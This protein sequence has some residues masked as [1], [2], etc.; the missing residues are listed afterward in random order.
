MRDRDWRILKE[1]FHIATKGGSIPNP[2]R[3]WREASISQD[4]LD[5]L[6]KFSYYEPSAI[7]RQA[8][9]II[10]QG[11][12]M[13]GVAETGS[14]KT[15]AFLVPLFEILDRT[16]YDNPVAHQGPFALIL[17]PTREL[18]LQIEAECARFAKFLGKRPPVAVVGG[19]S[20]AEQSFR[21][22]R[23]VDIVVATPG[24]LKD[25]LEQHILSLEHVTYTVFDEADRMVDMGFEADLSFILSKLRPSASNRASLADHFASSNTKS[26]RGPQMIMFSATM[27]PAVERLVRTYLSNPATVTI[28]IIGQVVDTIEQKVELMQESQKR[29]RLFAL[30]ETVAITGP[31]IVFANLKDTIDSLVRHMTS[32]GFGVIGLHGG[33][34]QEQRE[35]ALSKLKSG[36]INILVAT[37]VASRGI[38]VPDVALV[39]NFDM[40]SSI[41][42]YIHRIGRTGRAGK[43]GLAYT[44]LTQENAP[45]FY[46]L[47]ALLLSS[48]RSTCPP[49]LAFHEAANVKPGSF[50]QKKKSDETI[51]K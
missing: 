30:L 37:D 35:S 3:Y 16:Y 6:R 50:I 32:R 33:K 21:L 40:A 41:E 10:T 17:A 5:A 38:D 24:R 23:G 49:E 42:T 47:K 11:R 44:F 43:A 29:N 8:I 22:S 1:D 48:P 2:L 20:M 4:I 19:H 34:S 18:V 46:D 26:R 45:L 39:V 31:V 51:F 7:Q 36:K 28:G 14:G 25:C 27:P 12:D 9:P 13:L 15:V